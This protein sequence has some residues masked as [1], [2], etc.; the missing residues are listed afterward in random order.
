MSKKAN[1]V[2]KGASNHNNSTGKYY[3]FGNK[4]AYELMGIYL[5]DSMQLNLIKEKKRESIVD[6]AQRSENIYAF[7]LYTLIE[8]IGGAVCNIANLI[9]LYLMLHS[10][11]KAI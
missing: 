6:F 1:V 8:K 7:H 4:G 10:K 3:S 5:W 9:Y 2:K 11:C